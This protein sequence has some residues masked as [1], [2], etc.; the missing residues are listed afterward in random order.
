MRNQ[1][2]EVLL[3]SHCSVKEH[4]FKLN[5]DS[6]CLLARINPAPPGFPS[7]GRSDPAERLT[8]PPKPGLQLPTGLQGLCPRGSSVNIHSIPREGGSRLPPGA[9]MP[10]APGSAAPGSSERP[11]VAGLSPLPGR[12]APASLA[13]GSPRTGPRAGA[14]AIRAPWLLLPGP[15][16]PAKLPPKGQCSLELVLGAGSPFFSPS[17]LFVRRGSPPLS[18]RPSPLPP[19]VGTAPLDQASFFPRHLIAGKSPN[20]LFFSFFSLSISVTF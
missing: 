5:S 17:R 18:L 1:V 4:E 8:H 3:G 2:R 9:Q 15:P 19:L 7:R 20:F 13:W 11:S 16:S 10:S 14:A 6:S 12:P